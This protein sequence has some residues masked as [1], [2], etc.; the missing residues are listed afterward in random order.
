MSSIDNLIDQR[1]P[2]GVQF[3]PLAELTSSVGKVR[4]DL[5][6]APLRYVDLSS[7]D[8]VTHQIGESVRVDSHSAP[9]RAQQ[10]I[11]S[12]D[13][14]FG[15]TRP[16]LKRY[17]LVPPE[18]DGQVCSTGFCVLRPDPGV[19]LPRFL[20]HLLG[21]PNFYR[22][23]EAN[24]QG[25]GYPAISD[26]RVKEHRIPAPPLDVQR[27][28]VRILDAF[29]ELEAELEARRVQYNYYR[30]CFFDRVT[31]DSAALSSLGRWYG[32]VTPSKSNP[33]YWDGGSIPWL[34]SMDVSNFTNTIRGR[35][36]P[37]AL[38]ETPLRVIPAP[39]VAVVMRSNILRRILPI[40]LIEVD[41]TVNQDVRVLV[42]HD[43]VDAG[44]VFQALRADSEQIRSSCVR[45]DGS[46]AAV[47]SKSF[48]AWQIP[49]PSLSEQRRI[50]EKLRAFDALVSDLSIGLPAELAAR[51]KQYEYY[52]DRLLTFKEAA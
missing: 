13:V 30:Q 11:R 15:A 17:S 38:D 9:D 23:I 1:C 35:V 12:G 37:L 14:L 8:R 10:L 43:G 44:Y 41:T 45:T 19:L 31:A 34:A 51:R 46:M 5:V 47:D 27:E 48:F 33:S 36:T 42:P 7:I 2:D 32:G 20:F 18:Y 4:W 28:I 3:R 21:S 52:R 25:T 6:T 29:A 40:G 49:L 39:S 50:A 24:Q 22:H 16:M 26:K